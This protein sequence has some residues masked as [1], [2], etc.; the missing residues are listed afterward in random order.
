MRYRSVPLFLSNGT[1]CVYKSQAV[2]KIGEVKLLVQVMFVDNRPPFKLR[3][4]RFVFRRC[5]R[6]DATTARFAGLI[7]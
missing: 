3:Q 2:D 7:R 1:D 4:Q 5:E 6:R